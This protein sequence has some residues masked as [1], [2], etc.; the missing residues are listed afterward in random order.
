MDTSQLRLGNLIIPAGESNAPICRV[1]EIAEKY[2][3]AKTSHVDNIY[4]G[5]DSILPIQ[6]TDELLVELGFEYSKITDKFFTKDIRFGIS[7]ADNKFRFIQGNFVCQLVLKELKYIHELQN[8]YFTL[9]GNEL[10]IKI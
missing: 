6:L 3:I 8:L 2:V 7:T 9:T 4:I 1:I 10:E 5:K